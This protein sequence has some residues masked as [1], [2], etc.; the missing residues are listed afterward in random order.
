VQNG[1]SSR[2]ASQQAEYC[3]RLL[4]EKMVQ[5]RQQTEPHSGENKPLDERRHP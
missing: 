1:N 4:K 2:T 3:S 5:Q